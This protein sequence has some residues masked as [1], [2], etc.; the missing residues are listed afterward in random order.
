[1]VGFKIVTLFADKPDCPNILQN[2][3]ITS[4]VRDTKVDLDDIEDVQSFIKT[5]PENIR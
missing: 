5:I 1:M 2:K 4:F 3:F